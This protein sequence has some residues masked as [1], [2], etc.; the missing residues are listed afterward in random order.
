MKEVIQGFLPEE[1]VFLNLVCERISQ[2][3]GIEDVALDVFM[4]EGDDEEHKKQMYHNV[5]GFESQNQDD[6]WHVLFYLDMLREDKSIVV[7]V[8]GRSKRFFY[9]EW[10]FLV[11][12]VA[13]AIA[14]FRDK[15]YECSIF[16]HY[17]GRKW[18]R[19]P[20]TSYMAMRTVDQW[21]E[22]NED[23]QFFKRLFSPY[24]KDYFEEIDLL[25]MGASMIMVIKKAVLTYAESKGDEGMLSIEIEP[26]EKQM[27]RAFGDVARDDDVSTEMKITK[28]YKMNG[29]TQVP[30]GAGQGDEIRLQLTY[31]YEDEGEVCTAPLMNVSVLTWT[32]GGIK[33]HEYRMKVLAAVV[34]YVQLW[35]E[36][37]GACGYTIETTE[38]DYRF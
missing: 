16:K 32:F 11:T 2:E 35:C 17:N 27:R 23:Y 30:P 7:D 38:R 25:G 29:M 36:I 15:R 14:K 12:G 21:M 28:C 31:D 33:T 13:R 34:M 37:T 8:Y 3:Q 26:F 24:V 9:H 6:G 1:L 5:I 22:E 4:I 20:I 10:A 18:T 19:M